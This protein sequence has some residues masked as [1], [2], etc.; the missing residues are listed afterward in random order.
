MTM[1]K[2]ITFGAICCFLA[3]GCVSTTTGSIEREADDSDAAELNYTLGIRYLQAG[4]YELAR[5]RLVLATQ[6]DPK[7][8]TAYSALGRAYE[9]IGNNRLATDAYERSVRV[10]PRDFSVQNAYAIF[11]CRQRNYKDAEKAFNKAIEHPENDDAH[12]TMTNAGMCMSQMPDFVK[13]EAYFRAAI[14]RKPGYGEGLLQLCLMK[15]AQKDF[16]SARAFLQRYMSSNATTA[17]VLYL[18]SRIEGE[19][20]NDRGRTEYENQLLR[21]FPTSAEAKRV[22]GSS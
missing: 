5:D 8:G 4:S 14:D 15:Y 1:K 10:S 16:M 17:G 11:L 19:L 7:M 18:A 6:I 9:E 3:S 21:E 12:V 20:G 13:A 22:L 2:L